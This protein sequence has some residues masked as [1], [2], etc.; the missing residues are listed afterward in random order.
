MLTIDRTLLLTHTILL[1]WPN[2][3]SPCMRHQG[4]AE[5]TGLFYVSS[6]YFYDS[7]TKTEFQ[8]WRAATASLDALNNVHEAEK[9]VLGK[10]NRWISIW[11]ES[12]ADADED[13]ENAVRTAQ[14]LAYALRDI[15]GSCERETKYGLLRLR[16]P[17]S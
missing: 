1:E 3:L 10:A 16:L 11:P 17:H 5:G 14:G 2:L 12:P 15:R 6:D 8:C 13:Y 9:G 4:T 7:S